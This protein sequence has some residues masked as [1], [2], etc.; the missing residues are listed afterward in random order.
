VLEKF[1]GHDIDP[2]IGA[3]CGKDYGYQEV[4]RIF[5][6]QFGLCHR[7]VFRKMLDKGFVSLFFKH[8]VCGVGLVF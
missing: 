8:G 4:E 7:H 5:V 3:L 6:V 1:S 2:L